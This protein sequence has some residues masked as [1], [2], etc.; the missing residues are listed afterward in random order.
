MIM[1]SQYLPVA[2]AALR[3]GTISNDPVELT[4]AHV[5]ATLDVYL[6]ATEGG[7]NSNA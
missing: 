4:M 5:M 1:V 7:E 3:E 2:Y 6:K